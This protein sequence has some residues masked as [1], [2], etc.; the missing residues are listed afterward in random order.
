MADEV[1]YEARDGVAWLTINR[2]QARNALNLAARE[3]FN[4]SAKAFAADPQAQMRSELIQAA[5]EMASAIVANTP[6]SVQIK[7]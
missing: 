3:K 2:P 7:A 1:L 4:A 5:E 6:L